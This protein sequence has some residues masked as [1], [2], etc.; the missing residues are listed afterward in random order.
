MGTT[1]IALSLSA[2]PRTEWLWQAVKAEFQGRGED[3][4]G[5]EEEMREYLLQEMGL[6]L[7][8]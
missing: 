4:L 5:G 6:E 2:E 7:V 8:P 3:E 1:L